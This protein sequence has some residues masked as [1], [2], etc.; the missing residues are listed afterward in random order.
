[1]R[2]V[3]FILIDI[4]EGRVA[5]VFGDKGGVIRQGNGA[6]ANYRNSETLTLG[7]FSFRY[8]TSNQN[9]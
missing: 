3:G 4:N 7:T 5:E 8:L 2:L 9:L 6:Q 1:M